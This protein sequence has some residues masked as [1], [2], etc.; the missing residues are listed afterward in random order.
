LKSVS[1]GFIVAGIVPLLRDI[2]ITRSRFE[3]DLFCFGGQNS[4]WWALHETF[5]SSLDNHYKIN[6]HPMSKKIFYLGALAT[7]LYWWYANR[8]NKNIDSILQE[9]TLHQSEIIQ[10][11]ET[12]EKIVFFDAT[13]LADAESLELHIHAHDEVA[14]FAITK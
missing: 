13:Q 11:G 2:E 1:L 3:E 9:F 14:S 7:P 6:L 10:P 4:F 5:F 8:Y 12:L